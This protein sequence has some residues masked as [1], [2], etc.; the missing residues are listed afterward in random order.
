MKRLLAR[1]LMLAIVF[2]ATGIAT[3]SQFELGVEDRTRLGLTVFNSNLTVVRDQREVVL[4]TGEIELEFT[5]VA[6][7]I[8]PPTVSISSAASRG[9][10]ANQQNYRFDL[11][12]PNSLLERFVGSKVK[13][14]KFLLQ[15]KGYEKILREGILLSINPEIVKFG[16]VIEIAPEGTISLP[17]VREDLNTSPTLVFKGENQKSGKQELTVRY[18]A[19]GVGWEAD[20]ALTLEK[21]ASLSGWVT[22]R[23]QSS[24]D[25]AVDE[26]VLVAGDVNRNPGV[27]KVMAEVQHMRTTASFDSASPVTSNPGDYHAYRF[28]GQVN[29]LSHD[30]TQLKLISADA[31]RYE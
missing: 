23:N 24:S 12:N 26:L 4:P 13:Y 3:A 22:I 15:E 29:L 28:P 8:L 7:T 2:L 20:Y 18:H 16:D 27:P 14:S 19:A 11:L 31:I 9:F 1:F 30:M 6:R 5:D 21:E 25:F 10:S 17:Y